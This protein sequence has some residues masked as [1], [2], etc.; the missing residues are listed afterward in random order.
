MR[1][2]SYFL[3]ISILKMSSQ[4]SRVVHHQPDTLHREGTFKI[5]NRDT[6]LNFTP[7]TW[8]PQ[9]SFSATASQSAHEGKRYGKRAKP[10]TYVCAARTQPRRYSVS[11]LQGTLRCQSLNFSPSFNRCSGLSIQQEELKHWPDGQPQSTPQNHTDRPTGCK[12]TRTDLDTHRIC[13]RVHRS[14]HMNTI[15]DT[16][17]HCGRKCMYNNDNYFLKKTSRGI[18]YHTEDTHSKS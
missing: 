9:L 6:V 1:P 11:N 4:A 13:T 5:F 14:Q 3:S 12:L 18:F 10:G 8:E 17:T 16:H 2:S 15:G 7:L